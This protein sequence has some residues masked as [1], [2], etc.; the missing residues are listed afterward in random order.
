MTNYLLKLKKKMRNIIT[1]TYTLIIELI[2]ERP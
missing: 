1:Y 2:I